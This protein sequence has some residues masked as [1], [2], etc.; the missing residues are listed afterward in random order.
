[1]PVGGSLSGLSPG[2]LVLIPEGL[3]RHHG[4]ITRLDLPTT[5]V[6]VAHM[7]RAIGASHSSQHARASGTGNVLVAPLLQRTEHHLEFSSG[8]GEPIS[9]SSTRIDPDR[10]LW[11]RPGCQE[12][13]RSVSRR[14]TDRPRERHFRYVNGGFQ[15]DDPLFFH[16][17]VGAPTKGTGARPRSMFTL[18]AMEST[19]RPRRPMGGMLLLVETPPSAAVIKQ[20]TLVSALK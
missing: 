12:G 6:D 20:R 13:Y 10:N 18:R 5:F 3:C 8:G 7:N 19:K 4:D 9:E 16:E 15:G 14:T 11:A 1:V 2:S 17:G